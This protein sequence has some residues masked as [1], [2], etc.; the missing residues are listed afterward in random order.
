M[1]SSPSNGK[2]TSKPQ[3]RLSSCI[4]RWF[5]SPRSCPNLCGALLCCEGETMLQLPLE[6]LALS[7]CALV[8][9]GGSCTEQGG[10]GLENAWCFR[11][12]K[13]I[14]AVSW[15]VPLLLDHR[16]RTGTGKTIWFYVGHCTCRALGRGTYKAKREQRFSCLHGGGGFGFVLLLLLTTS[17]GSDFPA[18]S[19]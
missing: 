17:D 2:N 11:P 18:C 6:S 1:V 16:K 13:A 4:P 10:T 3:L 15:E 8:H 14:P 5:C 19:G 12:R 7:C 9:S